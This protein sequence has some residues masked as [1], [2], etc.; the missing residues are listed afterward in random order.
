MPTARAESIVLRS[1]AWMPEYAP[2]RIDGIARMTN[3]A[4]AAMGRCT[5]PTRVMSRSIRPNDGSARA[6]PAMP[7]AISLP[8]PVCPMRYPT[9]MAIADAM[10]IEITV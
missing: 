6:A 7:T 5:T 3:A 10:R 1:M 4:N 9:G 8:L 2:A